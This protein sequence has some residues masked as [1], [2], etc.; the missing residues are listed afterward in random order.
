MK[1]LDT[2]FLISFLKGDA[3]AKRYLDDGDSY[4]ATTVINSYEVT[5]VTKGIHEKRRRKAL[6]I[7]SNLY[8]HPLELEDALSASKIASD[9]AK[10][11]QMIGTLDTLIAGIVK[12][13]GCT[14]VTRDEHFR[15]I[16]DLDVERW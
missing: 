7:F 9:L 6:D 14:L 5:Y 16:E 11:G 15:R 8:I 10:E 12:N 3:E 4:Y 2:D 1:V 13:R